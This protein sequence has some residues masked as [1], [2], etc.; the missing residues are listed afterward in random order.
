MNGYSGGSHQARPNPS[1]P[2]A[3]RRAIG[4][5]WRPM[6]A[7]RIPMGQVSVTMGL[8]GPSTRP[9]WK[10]QRCYKTGREA[11]CI[12]F[13]VSGVSGL[14]GF[15]TR[16][17]P[18]ARIAIHMGTMRPWSDDYCA[19]RGVRPV[20]RWRPCRIRPRG[21]RYGIRARVCCPACRSSPVD[22]PRVPH[23]LSPP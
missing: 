14:S 3:M 23:P 4:G 19:G 2:R 12:G 18:M 22:R 20:S 6:G 8:D 21:G 11:P 5:P 9:R 17:F 7:M 10:N 1:S 15:M 13:Q 16:W